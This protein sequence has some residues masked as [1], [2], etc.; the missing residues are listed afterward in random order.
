MGISFVVRLKNIYSLK[1]PRNEKVKKYRFQNIVTLIPS[2]V[3]LTNEFNLNR[4]N[5][6][7]I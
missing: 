6:S 2:V 4:L 1:N 3:S 7:I 5:I